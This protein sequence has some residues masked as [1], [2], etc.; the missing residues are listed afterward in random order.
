MRGRAYTWSNTRVKEKVGLYLRRG[1]YAR[2]GGLIGGEIRY[3]I[4][5]DLVS[6][7][8]FTLKHWVLLYLIY[9]CF[10]SLEGGGGGRGEGD[11]GIT[12]EMPT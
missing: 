4:L 8:L 3:I 12:S 11:Y 7:D 5:R 10:S 2:G 9:N 6:W 1:L